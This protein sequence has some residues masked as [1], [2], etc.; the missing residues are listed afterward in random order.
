MTEQELYE[1]IGNL[2]FD[3]ASTVGSGSEALTDTNLKEYAITWAYH[4]NLV[5]GNR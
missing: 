3:I 4:G 2:P 5:P 1:A